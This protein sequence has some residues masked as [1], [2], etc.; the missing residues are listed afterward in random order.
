MKHH[1]WIKK[2]GN[3]M[4][5]WIVTNAATIIITL[6]ILGLVFLAGRSVYRSKG[7]CGCSG[8]GGSCGGC[9]GCSEDKVSK[10]KQKH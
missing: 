6:I 8:C 2:R 10:I 1:E 3:G 5:S 9:H 7:S 4:I